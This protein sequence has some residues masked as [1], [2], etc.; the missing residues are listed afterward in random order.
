[1]F[2]AI[3][4]APVRQ[5]LFIAKFMRNLKA[6]RVECRRLVPKADHFLVKIEKRVGF[7]GLRLDVYF[8]EA[9]RYWQPGF[10]TIRAEACIRFFTP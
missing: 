4:N 2:F 9:F 8:L 6:A 10:G 1:M 3:P 5:N 7:D